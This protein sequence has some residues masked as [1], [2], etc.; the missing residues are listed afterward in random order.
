M[1]LLT[2][3]AREISNVFQLLGH[4]ED[5]MTFSL[6]WALRQSPTFLQ[7]VLRHIGINSEI[8]NASLH[9]QRARKGFG[10]TDIEIELQSYGRILVEA[11]RSYS[12]PSYG[13]L[14][15]YVRGSAS[16]RRD[17]LPLKQVVIPTAF[18]EDVM[19]R[20]P[21]TPKT[22][23][24]I[25]VCHL[26]WRTVIQLA[27]S[28][29][30]A[31][32]GFQKNILGEFIDYLSELVSMQN[33]E[34]NMVYVVSLSDDTFAGG[35]ISFIDV[36]AEF[37]MYFHPVGNHYPTVPPNYLGFRYRSRLQSIHFVEDVTVIDE[38]GDHFPGTSH[39]K[40]VPHFLY[41]LGPPVRPNQEV[42][43]GPI[44]NMRCF[45]MLDTLLTSET[46]QQARQETQRRLDAC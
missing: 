6:G 3:H 15:Q 17:G 23:K 25:P 10:R 22:V 30:G 24:A 44:R 46:I 33:R 21:A 14:E 12:M 40:I 29:Y 42:R 8:D 41:R 43:S 26:S 32:R 27:S 5:D 39:E 13:Q 18:P 1:T 38:Y 2:A 11:K 45:C 35:D 34:S 7:S 19:E 36:V 20:E 9:L 28:S 16:E 4:K 31:V 37:G